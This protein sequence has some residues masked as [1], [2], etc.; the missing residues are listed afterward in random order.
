MIILTILEVL[1]LYRC[2]YRFTVHI[3]PTIMTN[4]DGDLWIFRVG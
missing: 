1:G 2:L 4:C 3:V